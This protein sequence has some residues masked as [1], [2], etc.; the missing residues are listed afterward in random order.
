[1]VN[2][3]KQRLIFLSR[4]LYSPKTIGSITPSSKH[5][6][7]ALMNPIPWHNLKSIVELGSG[8]GIVTH[9]ILQRAPSDCHV[10][11]FEQ[12][13]ALRQYLHHRYPHI[14]LFS[15]AQYLTQK[16]KQLQLKQVDCIVS[17]LPLTNFHPSLRADILNEI[18]NALTPNGLYIQYQYSLHL[19]KWLE[20]RFSSVNI[21]FIPLNIPPSFIFICKN[22]IQ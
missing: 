9:E 20:V 17:C 10:V 22:F 12:D 2:S 3:L 6:V 1:L 4:F 15:D 11:L 19:K 8:T 7:H 18:Q 5:L 21:R 14:S 16:L 13:Q